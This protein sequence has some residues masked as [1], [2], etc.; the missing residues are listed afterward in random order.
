L[1][2]QNIATGIAGLGSVLG[3]LTE[4]EV[5]A[6]LV[7]INNS[8]AP[9]NSI[10][11]L[12]NRLSDT[13]EVGPAWIRI[14]K[15]RE[16]ASPVEAADGLVAPGAA[17]YVV[18]IPG[19]QAWGPKTGTNPLDLTSNFSAISKTGFAGSERAVELAMKQAGIRADSQLLLVGHSQGGLV[20]AN[21]STRY[22]GSKTLTFGAPIGQ[23]GT[24][25]A[26]DTLAVEHKNDPVPRLDGKP[27][28][29]ATNW[30]TV[31]QDIPVN[32]PIAQHSMA[33]YRETSAEIDAAA[34][35]G[36]D[37]AGFKRIREEIVSFSG[38]ARGQALYFELK[39]KP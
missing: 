28:P 34:E 10:S 5:S 29:M 25:L 26:A 36:V 38:T 14:E 17:R 16:P 21:I 18:Y 23:L 33:G 32:D 9:A 7:S 12:A 6:D 30:V 20:A 31:R 19:T 37:N 4:T 3:V 1:P 2:V 13:A 27:N 15:F 8:V 39:R 35:V 24:A 11:E 22:A